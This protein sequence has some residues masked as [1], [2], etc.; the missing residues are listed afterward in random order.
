MLLRSPRLAL[1]LSIHLQLYRCG[2]VRQRRPRQGNLRHTSR[3]LRHH[4][5]QFVNPCLQNNE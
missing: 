1:R 2:T 4:C 3:P 5:R